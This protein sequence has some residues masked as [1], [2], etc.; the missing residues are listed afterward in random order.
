MAKPPKLDRK[1]IKAPD[2]FVRQ[3]NR[4]LDLV[5]ENRQKVLILAI[6]LVLA[7]LVGYGY[8]SWNHSR[9]AQGWN[10]YAAAIK[11]P[12][13][14]R[15]DALKSGYEHGRKTRATFFMAVTVA[16]HAFD[17]ARAALLKDPSTVPP[18][19]AEAADWYSKA[20]SYRDLLPSE[21]QLLLIDRGQAYE[22][23]KKFDLA[24]K[25]YQEAAS[26]GGTLKGYALLNQGRLYELMQNKAQAQQTYEQVA[27][28][29]LN[30]QYGQLAKNYL[31]RLK[32]PLLGSVK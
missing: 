10:A 29:F 19:L 9:L 6:V 7:V 20:L 8:Q 25:D 30:T 32:S 22:M 11:L 31:R 26:L 2:D 14:Q 27:S 5:A 4:I 28:D 17:T 23:E 16:D 3:G 13:P 21:R 12:E 24:G 1:S 18:T 15:Y